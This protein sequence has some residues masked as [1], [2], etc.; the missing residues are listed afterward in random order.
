MSFEQTIKSEPLILTECA[1]A[2]RLRR[3]DDIVLHP[4][5]FNTPLIYDDVGS[6]RLRDI[7]GQYRSIADS[8]KLPILLCAPTWRVDRQRTIAGG[9]GLHLNR[10]AVQFMR[11][12]Q[13]SWH[14]PSSPVYVGGLIGPK[15]D[16]Y[17]PKE[18]L[19]MQE[20]HSYHSWQSKELIQ[21]GVD[22]IVCQ[23]IPAVSEALGLAQLLGP[24]NVPYL[25]SFVIN[26]KAE[27]L[28]GTPLKNAIAAIDQKVSIPPTGYMVN[29]A[30][31]SFVCASKQEPRLFKRLIGIQANASSLDHSQLDGSESLQKDP[32]D[33]WGAQMLILNRTYGVKILGGCCGTDDSYL[34]Y[35]VSCEQQ[36]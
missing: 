3:M 22:C 15:N 21:A 7:Y 24:M 12:L 26:R 29:C 23:T 11:N 14:N 30:F 2:E 18:A 33:S 1:I 4:T 13:K 20:A 10:D 35:L 16:C 27:V 19:S 5:L 36:L 25:I 31:P 6:R 9:M 32:L 8:A 17:S 34:R 28:D